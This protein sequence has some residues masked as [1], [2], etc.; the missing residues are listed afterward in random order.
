MFVALRCFLWLFDYRKTQTHS[1]YLIKRG[2]F[3]I[4]CEPKLQRRLVYSLDFCRTF[5]FSLYSC[6]Q[7]SHSIFL[8]PMFSLFSSL[9]EWW[10]S[11]YLVSSVITIFLLEVAF[12]MNNKQ[13]NGLYMKRLLTA[14]KSNQLIIVPE[15][16][17]NSFSMS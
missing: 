17:S 3:K 8:F 10:I 16:K 13:C 5:S 4:T 12:L 1:I 9:H 2:I 7:I 6:F 14:Q 11:T 15:K